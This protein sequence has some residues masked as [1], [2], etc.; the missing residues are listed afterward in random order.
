MTGRTATADEY[1]AV[2]KVYEDLICQTYKKLGGDDTYLRRRSEKFAGI[3]SDQKTVGSRQSCYLL[4]RDLREEI[5]GF[6][7]AEIE[8]IN[9]KIRTALG[10]GTKYTIGVA[11]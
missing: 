6:R 8:V 5:I 3:V 9:Q 1:L 2:A 11:S 10:T 4:Y 7:P